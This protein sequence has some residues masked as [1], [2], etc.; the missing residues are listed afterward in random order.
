VG[1]L[2]IDKAPLVA[3]QYKVQSIPTLI[4]FKDGQPIETMV[5]MQRADAILAKLTAVAQ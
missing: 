2:D 1:K 5:G 4:L 3:A